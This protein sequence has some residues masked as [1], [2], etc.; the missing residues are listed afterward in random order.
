MIAVE[1]GR[2]TSCCEGED[3]VGGQVTY[4]AWLVACGVGHSFSS[5]M[6]TVSQIDQAITM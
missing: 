5:N 2:E 3:E 1:Y 6:C 4:G